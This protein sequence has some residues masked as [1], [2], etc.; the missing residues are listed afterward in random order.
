[1]CDAL[2]LVEL[3]VQQ[4]ELDRK[5]RLPGNNSQHCRKLR[6]FEDF[7]NLLPRSQQMPA[8]IPVEDNRREVTLR[9][10]TRV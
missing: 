9:A 3:N 10:E 5:R 6:I 2:R 4:L 7:A 8:T 1:M